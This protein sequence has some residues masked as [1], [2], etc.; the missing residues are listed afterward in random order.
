MQDYRIIKIS[1][2]DASSTEPITASQVKLE[3]RIDFAT[4]DTFITTLI[5]VAR[6]I[7]EESAAISLKEKEVVLTIE[8]NNSCKWIELPYGIIQSVDGVA[9]ED[10]NDL[11]EGEGYDVRGEEGTFM[12]I[13][14]NQTGTFTITYTA[15]Y[16][17][18]PALAKQA[19]I[20][21]VVDNYDGKPLA[22][23]TAKHLIKPLKRMQWL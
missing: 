21:E 10:G 16:E 14:L 7:L 8:I 17:E 11:E 9:D 23:R 18:L 20:R 12:E 3:A 5:P 13:R 6:E 15:G 19:L 22:E 4:D 2:T 1:K